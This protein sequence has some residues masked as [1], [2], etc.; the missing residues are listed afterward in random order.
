[1][2]VMVVMFTACSKDSELFTP[3][4]TFENIEKKESSKGKGDNSKPNGGDTATD[5][6]PAD[7]SKPDGDAPIN[8]GGG[9][10]DDDDDESDDDTASRTTSPN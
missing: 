7:T 3:S 1:M 8:G 6:L 2:I 10:S 5:G 9:I 4:E